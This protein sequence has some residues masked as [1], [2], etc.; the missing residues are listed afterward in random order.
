MIKIEVNKKQLAHIFACL[1]TLRALVEGFH[2]SIPEESAREFALLLK[3]NLTSQKFAAGYPA[4][5]AWKKN[6]PNSNK[7]WEWYGEALASIKYYK[8][9]TGEWFAGFGSAGVTRS[10]S[11]AISKARMS[12]TAVKRINGKLMPVKAPVADRLSTIKKAVEKNLGLRELSPEV[13]ARIGKG[14]VPEK[15]T[16]AGIS[17][18]GHEGPKIIKRQRN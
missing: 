1:A 9:G 17:S 8:V 18:F 7:F 14:Y 13:A 11:K 16:S 4:L 10:L 6:E 5:K 2:N 3:T 15:K 12:K